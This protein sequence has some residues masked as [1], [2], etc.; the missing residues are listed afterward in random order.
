MYKKNVR[1]MALILTLVMVLTAC[2]GSNVKII[3]RHMI[4][5]CLSTIIVIVTMEIPADIMQKE[6]RKVDKIEREVKVFKC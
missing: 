5:N 6:F 3:L 4:P 1:L 2:G